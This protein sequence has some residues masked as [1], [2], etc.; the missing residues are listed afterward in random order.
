MFGIFDWYG[1][2]DVDWYDDALSYF[3][4]EEIMD[5]CEEDEEDES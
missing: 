4:F 5:E 2:G 3:I 1:D